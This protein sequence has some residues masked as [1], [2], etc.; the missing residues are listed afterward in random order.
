MA[1]R[2]KRPRHSFDCYLGSPE[3]KQALQ[4]RIER[5]RKKLSPAGRTI[6]NLSLINAMLDAVEEKLAS[7]DE[8]TP[9]SDQGSV[10]PFLRDNG[11][12]NSLLFT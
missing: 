11:E 9:T 10:R 2:R 8:G 5:V 12:C 7:A 4:A 6:D 1:N 3:E